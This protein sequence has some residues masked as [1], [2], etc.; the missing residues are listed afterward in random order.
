MMPQFWDVSVRVLSL[1]SQAPHK[2]V[3]FSL[4]YQAHD[5]EAANGSP[6]FPT[7]VH[8]W[9]FGQAIFT[10]GLYMVTV[11]APLTKL[12]KQ[13]PHL[14]LLDI[15][16]ILHWA[17]VCWQM[18]VWTGNDFV[19]FCLFVMFDRVFFCPLLCA[20]SSLGGIPSRSAWRR[21]DLLSSQGDESHLPQRIQGATS[22]GSG[23]GWV[24]TW[25]NKATFPS[26]KMNNWAPLF[27]VGGRWIQGVSVC[28]CVV[29]AYGHVV[30]VCVCAM[31]VCV[32]YVLCMCVWCTSVCVYVMCT[33]LS[34]SWTLRFRK[35]CF[36]QFSEGEGHTSH[37]CTRQHHYVL[38]F[39]GYFCQF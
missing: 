19:I 17:S 33:N 8:H 13:S 30:D 36:F 32:V 1:R 26:G 37:V 23:G 24:V 5:D 4:E 10:S 27:G 11:S 35:K 7:D 18:S 12:N 25:T 14:V 28:A 39:C 3:C 15:N 22:W 16:N 9:F 38:T 29:C 34:V 6:A 31:R 20:T 2:H 21:T